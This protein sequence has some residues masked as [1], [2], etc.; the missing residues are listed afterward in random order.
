VSRDFYRQRM[1]QAER[2]AFADQPLVQRSHERAIERVRE[3]TRTCAPWREAAGPVAVDK[4]LEITIARG[5]GSWASSSEWRLSLSRSHVCQD[6]VLLHELA[7]LPIPDTFPAHGREFALLYINVVADVYH[8]DIAAKLKEALVAKGVPVSRDAAYVSYLRRNITRACSQSELFK[9][10]YVITTR[11]Q[12]VY[13]TNKTADFE[14]D[15]LYTK[16][17]VVQHPSGAAATPSSLTL[18][19]IAYFTAIKKTKHELARERLLE[20]RG[21]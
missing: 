17:R 1:Y 15:I 7:H 14:G 11:G 5:A 6:W 9:E 13:C 12:Y 3:I 4:P 21:W 8:P 10:I 2:L 20:E 16:G 19:E 18:D